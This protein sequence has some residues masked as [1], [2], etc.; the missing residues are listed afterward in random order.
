[1]KGYLQYGTVIVDEAARASPRDL[2]IPMVQAKDRIILVGDHRQLP[3]IVDE[4]LLQQME[5][6]S[7]DIHSDIK[8]KFN[9]HITSSM[10]QYL[11][12]RAKQL[13]QQDGTPRTITLDAQ[14]RSHPLLG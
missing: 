6:E 11:F 7:D 3:H 13:E 1:G 2:M 8:E 10:F 12:H 9:Q 5:Q 14:Y 4:A